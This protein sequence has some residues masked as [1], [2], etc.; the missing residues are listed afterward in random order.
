MSAKKTSC[1]VI[2]L[3]VIAVCLVPTACYRTGEKIGVL[4]VIHGGQ[5]TSEAQ[6]MWDATI[7]Q[8]VYDPNHTVYKA[9]IWNPNA[10]PLVLHQEVA[11]KYLRKFDFCYERIGGTDPYRDIIANSLDHIKA[12]LDKNRA[13]ITFE[14][15]WTAYIVPDQ[16]SQLPN[17]RYLFY[18]PEGTGN[19]V[20]YCGEDEP[21]GL[22]PGC[23]PNRYDVDGSVDRMLKKNVSKIFLVDLAVGGVRFYKPHYVYQMAKRRVNEWNDENGS[24]VSLL[25]I[26]DFS[27]V[28][29]RSY[30]EAPEGWTP[31]LGL[32]VEGFKD[33]HVLLNGS[34]NPVAEDPDLAALHVEGIEARMSDMISDAETGVILFNHAIKNNGEVYDPKIN[35]TITISE[36]IKSELLRRH[37]DMD[38]AN[39]IG[40]YEGNAELNPENGIVEVHR[41]M[42]GE[43]RGYGHLYESEKEMPD[44]PWGYRNWDAL[45]YLKDRGV[46]HIVI[47]FPQIVLD[48]VLNLVE[49]PNEVAREI[50]YKT[51]AGSEDFNQFPGVGHPFAEFW[52]IWVDTECGGEPCCFEMGG[53]NDG[54]PYPPPRQAPIDKEM[55][56]LDPSLGFDVSDYG[57]LGYD[58]SLGPPDPNG[59]V[60]DQYTGTWDM[61]VCPNDDPRVG[62]LL[63][64]HVLNAAVKPMVYITNGEVEGVETGQAVTWH[65]HVVTGTPDYAYEWS[66]KQA[67]DTDWSSVGE[68]SSSWVWTPGSGETGTYNVRCQVKDAKGGNGEVVWED[69][70]ISD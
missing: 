1:C 47:G 29:D 17:P 46:K 9:I 20:T 31:S 64:K 52:G 55:L 34:P 23:D 44:E 49:L 38:P 4:Y 48:S 33:R 61:W 70:E 58:P 7:Q 22:W 16:I 21:D 63:A 36:N 5:D 3:L 65:G 2:L 25:W 39:I 62:K 59:P 43:D 15:D 68:N 14:V 8:F 42:R 24:S 26:N 51:W 27:N 67:G 56:E 19:D 41:G 66:I 40:S 6:F 32:D 60:Q 57:H 11:A 35:D 54:R 37:P 30:P 69:F 28:M 12:E 50:G 53:C 13:G 45:E 10:W 18:D